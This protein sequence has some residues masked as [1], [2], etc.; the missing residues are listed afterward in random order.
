MCG[1]SGV[2]SSRPIV[3]RLFEGIKN[4]EYRGYDSCG[5]AFVNPSKIQ[6]SKDKGYVDSVNETERISE[7]SGHIGIAHTRWATH[8]KVTKTNA[9]PHMCCRGDF[10]IVHNGIISNYRNLR[11]ELIEEGHQFSSETDSEVMAHLVEK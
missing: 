10:A 5:I 9:H 8:G 6:V 4:L 7:V 11:N 3:D 2:V 1:I